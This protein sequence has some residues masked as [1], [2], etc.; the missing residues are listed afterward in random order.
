MKSKYLII[1]IGIVFALFNTCHAINYKWSST[2]PVEFV[3]LS[4]IDNSKQLDYYLNKQN[5][6]VFYMDD[7][8]SIKTD[9][10]ILY[11]FNIT[12]ITP[13]KIPDYG[14]YTFVNANNVFVL[15]PKNCVYRDKD[16]ALIYN[17][18]MPVNNME[19]K[20]QHIPPVK[21]EKNELI[22]N[23]YDYVLLNNGTFFIYPKKYI[24]RSKDGSIIYNP[25][26]N[27]NNSDYELEYKNPIPEKMIPNYYDYVFVNK[28][29]FFIYP[30]KYIIRDKDGSI[31]FNPPVDVDKVPIYNVS[32]KL[33]DAEKGI[34]EIK[35]KKILITH[36]INPNED[37]QIMDFVGYYVSEY[38]GTFAYIDKV[39]AHYK[40]ALINGIVVQNA[41]PDEN[42][43]YAV[44]VAGRKIK[45]DLRDEG[46]INRKI[47]TIKGLSEILNINTTYITTGSENLKVISKENPNKD[48][49]NMLLNDYWFKKWY[50]NNYTHIY[51]NPSNIKNNYPINYFDIL[52]M[53]YYPMIYVDKAPETFQNDPVGGY[54][55]ETINYKGTPNEG[56]WEK[57]VD[58]ENKYYHYESGEPH[59]TDNNGEYGSNWYYEGKVVSPKNDSEMNNKYKYFNHWFV[60][61]YAYTLSEGVDGILLTSSDNH[62]VDAIFGKDNKNISWRLA[63]NNS[64]VD[65]IVL[66]NHKGVFK[67]NNI[68]IISV[69]GLT[70]NEVYGVHYIDEYYTPPKDEE[71]GVYVADIIK[72]DKNRIYDLKD[73]YTWICSF[74]NYAHW[75]DIYL[76][77]SIKIKNGSNIFIKSNNGVKITVYK[78]DINSSLITKLSTEEYD[79]NLNKVVIN[80][81]PNNL[82]LN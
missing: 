1:I 49:L 64:N 53:S 8:Y 63:I 42:G 35:P 23:Y 38:N 44:D 59:W 48:E 70:N 73:N 77:N 39:P 60:K 14:N 36:P 45:V 43:D 37:K 21:R 61:N 19:Y 46:L 20:I 41:I 75:A 7:N 16:G 25:P 55:P 71:F 54:Y 26:L 68:T 24:T 30:K 66:P 81:P 10:W 33:I 27:R 65:Y 6:V 78:K 18:P 47:K 62:L 74:K 17:T 76:T 13:S 80:N 22:P 31:L 40:H 69:P 58:S 34:Y 28:G 32:T 79:K 3:P 56:Y 29:V 2:I 57:G 12:R 50:H 5:I 9:E 82:I 72:Y 11:K 67:E 15:Y 52:A 51:Y 4:S